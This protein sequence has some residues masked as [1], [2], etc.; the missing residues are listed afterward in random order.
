MKKKL[1]NLPPQM[2][3]SFS[4]EKTHKTSIM[5]QIKKL[6]HINIAHIES[7]YILIYLISKIK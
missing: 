7:T 1:L 3:T 2:T 6:I 4:Y 5:F